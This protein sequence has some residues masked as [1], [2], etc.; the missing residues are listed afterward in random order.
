M[1]NEEVPNYGNVSNRQQSP[2]YWNRQRYRLMQHLKNEPSSVSSTLQ[3]V[4]EKFT[5]LE[6]STPIY[7]PKNERWIFL[8]FGEM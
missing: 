5:K 2:E 6:F 1:K 8:D 3:R 4:E 7:N